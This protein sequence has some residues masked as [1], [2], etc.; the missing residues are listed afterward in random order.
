MQ[1]TRKHT[2]A[3]THYAA[4]GLTKVA[5]G[6]LD[7]SLAGSLLNDISIVQAV[8]AAPDNT[9]TQM[10]VFDR[11]TD[12]GSADMY[13]YYYGMFQVSHL[14]TSHLILIG[15]RLCCARLGWM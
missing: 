5:G 8:P 11:K 3:H 13:F 6:S 15:S 7:L 9:A 1:S 10:N 14:I 2:R 12:K 4:S